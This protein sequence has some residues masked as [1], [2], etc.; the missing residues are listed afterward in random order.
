M[1][2][3]KLKDAGFFTVE[4]VAFAKESHV[5]DVYGISELKAEKIIVR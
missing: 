3:K 2:I 1:D 5:S 4:A